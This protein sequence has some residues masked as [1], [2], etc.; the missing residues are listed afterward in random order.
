MGGGIGLGLATHYSIAIA[1]IALCAASLLVSIVVVL[2]KD[3]PCNKEKTILHQVI[4]MGKD[5]LAMV[6]VPVAFFVIFLIL[7]PIGSGAMA[8]L[9]SAVAQD[10]KTDADTVVLVTGLLSGLVSALG[11]IAG[12]YIA[13]RWGVWIAY[14]GSG[15]VCALVTFLMAAMPYQPIVYTVG[16]LTY[17]FTMGL[18]YAAFTAVILFAI[19]KKHVATKFS[20]LA[21]LG[22]LP[23]VY[24][25]AF[26]GWV[27]DKYN[28]RYML[29]AEAAIGVFFV[30][31][32]FAILKRMM[33]KKM[34]T[35]ATV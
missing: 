26:N 33:H 28:S 2:I 23:V 5:V 24:M 25:T 29:I 22:N 16:V 9:W 14:L 1:G 4:V 31:I 7:M 17:A 35:V 18:I 32:F 27:H 10:W 15:S 12:G 21:S 3:I 19:G 20:L 13:D 30:L 8:N 6:K 11:C 34:I